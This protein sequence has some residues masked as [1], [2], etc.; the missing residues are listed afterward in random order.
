MESEFL[1]ESLLLWSLVSVKIDDLPSLVGSSMFLPN[2][3][4]L[5]FSILSLID[6]KYLLV[7]PVDEEFSFISED[8]PPS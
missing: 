8:L 1:V 2:N 4:C 5:S 7:L 3:N 6:I